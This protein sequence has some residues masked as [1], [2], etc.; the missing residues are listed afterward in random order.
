MSFEFQPKLCYH[1][2][3]SSPESLS[4]VSTDTRVKFNQILQNILDFKILF[5]LGHVASLWWKILSPLPTEKKI[6][7]VSM[8]YL[9]KSEWFHWVSE[10]VLRQA[11]PWPVIWETKWPIFYIFV[12]KKGATQSLV[13]YRFAQACDFFF[14]C[15]STVTTITRIFTTN[16]L[17]WHPSKPP[18]R[19]KPEKLLIYFQILT[20]T[21]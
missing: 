11:E 20:K 12:C 17:W 5:Q 15:I 18:I 6:T 3:R 4:T 10:L 7:P 19:K 16:N 2:L 13:P 21:S 14:Y 8:D 9:V 1:I